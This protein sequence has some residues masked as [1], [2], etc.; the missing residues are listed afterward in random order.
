MG[1][2]WLLAKT[3]VDELRLCRG[4]PGA[5]VLASKIECSWISAMSRNPGIFVFASKKTML[6]DFNSVRESWYS[7]LASNNSVSGLR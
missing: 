6:L 2:L 3:N 5:C 7:R 4:N 1:H